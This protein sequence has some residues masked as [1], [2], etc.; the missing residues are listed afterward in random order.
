MKS[1]LLLLL[2][3][4]PLC[5]FAKPD[6]PVPYAFPDS[7]YQQ[8]D[9]STFE[10]WAPINEK[11]D[12]NNVDYSLLQAAVFY[13]TNQYRVSKKLN[14]LQYQPTLGSAAIYQSSQMAEKRFYDHTNPYDRSMRTAMDRAKKYGF[15]GSMVGENIALEFLLNYKGQTKYWYELSRSGDYKYY[16]GDNRTNKGYV[17]L[18]SYLSLGQ[19]IVKAWINSP[20]HRANLLYKD[21]KYLGCGVHVEPQSQG[22]KNIPRIYATQVFG[23]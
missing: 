22:N 10:S 19:S 11:I 1:S 15:D 12:A 13:Y 3:A 14:L 21:F 9:W 17:P 23:G 6:E 5:V 16:Y 7:Y 18:H 2:F 20:D 4:L 8:F